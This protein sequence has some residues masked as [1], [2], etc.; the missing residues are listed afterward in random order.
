VG[1]RLALV[2]PH[3]SPLRTEAVGDF[4]QRHR[5]RHE[6]KAERGEEPRSEKGSD[7]DEQGLHAD[8]DRNAAEQQ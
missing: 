6:R 1:K 4:A 7:V 2:E 3:T 8:G 5:T